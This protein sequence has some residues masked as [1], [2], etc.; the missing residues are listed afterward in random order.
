MKNFENYYSYIIKIGTFTYRRILYFLYENSYPSGKF[1]PPQNK[2]SPLN[3]ENFLTPLYFSNP[4]SSNPPHLGGGG[5]YEVRKQGWLAG[6]FM[7][8]FVSR[9]ILS[10]RYVHAI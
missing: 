1:N 7:Y 9:T 4:K 5:S 10:R 8:P 6:Q 3:P 2:S